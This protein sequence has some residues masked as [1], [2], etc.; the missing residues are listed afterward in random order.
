[1][2]TRPALQLSWVE[3]QMVNYI[4]GAT[5]AEKERVVVVLREHLS[6]AQLLEIS[7]A[8]RE[9]LYRRGMPYGS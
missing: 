3:R 2:T 5:M 1:M 9:E 6:T 7:D 4:V 8:L